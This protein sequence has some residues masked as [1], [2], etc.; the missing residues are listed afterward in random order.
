MKR[1]KKRTNWNSLYLSEVDRTCSLTRENTELSS[2]CND[3][4]NERNR[5]EGNM[6]RCI[7]VILGYMHLHRKGNLWLC[8]CD[9]CGTGKALLELLGFEIG[10]RWPERPEHGDRLKYLERHNDRNL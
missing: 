1:K 9:L 6:N 4:Q 10:K 5:W 3:L 7:S 2:R 8:E